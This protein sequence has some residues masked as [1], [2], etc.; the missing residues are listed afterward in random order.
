MTHIA[1]KSL[2]QNFLT[3]QTALRAMATA[4]NV[5]AGDTVLE[6]G[7]GKGAL[8]EVLLKFGAHVIAVEKDRDLIPILEEKFAEQIKSK[9]L[10]LIEGDILDFDIKKYKIKKYKVIAN[11][12]YYITGL[13]IRLFLESDLQPETIVLLVQ[14]EVADRIV[15]RDKKESI[16]SLSVKAYGEPKYILK[17]SKKLFR[18]APKVDSAIIAINSIS[19]GAFKNKKEEERYFMIIKAGFAHKR[20]MLMGNL[21]E[22]ASRERLAEAFRTLDIPDT[23]RAEDVPLQKWVALAKIS[24]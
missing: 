6:I 18:P 23:A 4:G 24:V 9:Q 16:L 22:L 20:K 19:K 5:K 8:T 1:K 11:I 3:S 21:A 13:L 10:E 17:V 7:P 15:A 2:G 12:P 14:K